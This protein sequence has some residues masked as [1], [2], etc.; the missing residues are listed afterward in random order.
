ML[1]SCSH[2]GGGSAQPAAPLAVTTQALPDG[3]VNT[4]YSSTLSAA[5]G[6]VPYS[7]ELTSG[8]LP[9]GLALNSATGQITGT[10]T[11][12]R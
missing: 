4:A 12:L 6:T 1:G 8:A 11:T 7:W 10:P 2:V 3:Q 5:G 9:D